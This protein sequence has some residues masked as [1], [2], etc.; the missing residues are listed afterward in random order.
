[1]VKK[2]KKEFSIGDY[3][4]GSIMAE[5]VAGTMAQSTGSSVGSTMTANMMTGATKP[6]IP[7]MK[8]KGTTMVLKS[9]KGLNV[10]K[11]LIRGKKKYKNEL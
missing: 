8:I 7:V 11:K 2:K 1:M 5:T 3:V 6:V 10:T 4:G 9:L